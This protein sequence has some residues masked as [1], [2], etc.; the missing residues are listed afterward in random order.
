M[1]P[2]TRAYPL[3]KFLQFTE[4]SGLKKT[5]L[6]CGAG[7]TIPPLSL[8]YQFGYQTTG[9]DI[10]EQ[11]LERAKKFV[12]KHGINLN[13]NSGDMRDL[14]FA[15]ESFCFAYSYNSIFHM[16]KEE[17]KHSI[18]EMLRVLKVDG[19]IFVNLLSIDDQ[20]C[21]QGEKVGENEF[22]QM[23]EEPTIHSFH[24]DD[25]ANSLFVG[26]KIL[27]Q[28]KRY[29]ERIYAGRKI[30]QVYLDY[31]VKKVEKST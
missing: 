19:L 7:G 27:H 6:D 25:E 17:I 16:K 13:I 8:F 18:Q 5:I 23:E 21:G 3:Y 14:Q 22:L 2:V 9:I 11:S 1:L 29:I 20:M 28:E 4:E 31:I 10:S 26:Q 12:T 30:L 24:S 15:D